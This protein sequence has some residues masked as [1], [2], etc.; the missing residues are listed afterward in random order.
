MGIRTVSH[1]HGHRECAEYVEDVEDGGEKPLECASGTSSGEGQSAGVGAAA[2]VKEEARAGEGGEQGEKQGRKQGKH[3]E[4]QGRKQGKQGNKGDQGDQG[5][6]VQKCC[7]LFRRL[8]YDKDY[9]YGGEK[10]VSLV[11]CWPLTGRT[12]Q[13]RVHLQV[14]YILPTAHPTDCASYRL[15]ILQTAHPTDYA[16]YR[17]CCAPCC[18]L[19]CR[20]H[21]RLHCRLHCIHY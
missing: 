10:G 18:R 2:R 4:K 12:H 17:L 7:S 6:A 19:H 20:L 8:W 1:K 15:R 3:G 16:S 11:H 5:E 21:F 14:G 13:L 9:E